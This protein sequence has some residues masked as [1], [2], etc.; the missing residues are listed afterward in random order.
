MA[1]DWIEI[2][3]ISCVSIFDAPNYQLSKLLQF[4]FS[5]SPVEYLV[6]WEGADG[7]FMEIFFL[8]IHFEKL[9]HVLFITPGVDWM[10]SFFTDSFHLSDVS[11]DISFIIKLFILLF[12]W[13]F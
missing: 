13:L 12:K 6:Q 10:S 7:I 4:W 3:V 8:K 11:I 5:N 9:L 1:R 2:R